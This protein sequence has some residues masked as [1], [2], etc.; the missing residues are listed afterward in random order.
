MLSTLF[1]AVQDTLEGITDTQARGKYSGQQERGSTFHS[2]PD[3]EKSFFGDDLKTCPQCGSDLEP[4][5]TDAR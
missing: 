2:C 4:I 1:E 3:C 5:Q